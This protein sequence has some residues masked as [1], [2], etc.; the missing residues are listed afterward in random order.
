MA[1]RQ[2]P[3]TTLL[4]MMLAVIGAAVAFASWRYI[5]SMP[6]WSD[7]PESLQWYYFQ[8]LGSVAFLAPLSLTLLAIARRQSRDRFRRVISEP[9]TVVGLS[10]LFVLA[11]NTLLLLAIMILMGWSVATFADGKVL[12]YCRLLAEQT[13]MAIGSAWFI[14]ALSGR[15]RK[16]SGWVNV[17][18]WVVGACWILL[19]LASAAFTLL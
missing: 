8:A 13:G 10:T 15:F 1:N 4:D 17:S 16:A 11:T 2:H 7:F 14:Q 18:A 6:I 12:Y 3:K 5:M 19:A 9:S